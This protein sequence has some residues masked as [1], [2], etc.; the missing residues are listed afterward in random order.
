MDAVVAPDSLH[1]LVQ[2]TRILPSS[3]LHGG[4]I[5]GVARLRGHIPKLTEGGS[6]LSILRGSSVEHTL[7]LLDHHSRVL[8]H[9]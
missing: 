2:V 8:P 5:A 3:F 7:L 9:L 1:S 4:W 6:V